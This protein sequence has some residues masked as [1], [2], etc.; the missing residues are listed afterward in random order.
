MTITISTAQAINDLLTSD[1]ALAEELRHVSTT[2]ELTNKLATAAQAHGIA[3][4]QTA[5]NQELDLAL[6]LYTKNSELSD[7]QL[8]G[9]NGGFVLSTAL[10]SLL[11]AAGLAGTVTTVAVG[12]GGAVG[13]AGGGAVVGA[14]A[15]ADHVN[16]KYL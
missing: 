15:A 5:L 1:L 11:G 8:E 6:S 4:D 7:K 13:L 10:L 16:K 3:V 2:H 9:V 12:V 14:L